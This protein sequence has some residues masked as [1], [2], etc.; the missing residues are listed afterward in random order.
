[1]NSKKF[2]STTVETIIYCYHSQVYTYTR[3]QPFAQRTHTHIR[4]LSRSLSAQWWALFSRR[5]LAPAA[6]SVSNYSSAY[7]CWQVNQPTLIVRARD[8][9][10]TESGAAARINSDRR[11]SVCARRRPCASSDR[12]PPPPRVNL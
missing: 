12:W 9:A 11:R 5:C 2:R 7:L 4:S 6:E 8:F 1:M 10:H 3:R